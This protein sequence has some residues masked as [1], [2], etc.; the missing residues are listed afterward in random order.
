MDSLLS[1]EIDSLIH[2]QSDALQYIDAFKAFEDLV[3]DEDNAV[4]ETSNHGSTGGGVYDL[5]NKDDI[6]LMNMSF[7]TLDDKTKDG[8]EKFEGMKGKS[9][10]GSPREMGPPNEINKDNNHPQISCSN[11]SVMSMDD[12][13]S[14]RSS[15]DTDSNCNEETH[16]DSNC[17]EGTPPEV[18]AMHAGKRRNGHSRN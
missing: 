16:T 2:A 14:S 6:S 15:N 18:T 1:K 8:N 4:H 7:F 5:T 10:N 9:E 3:L 17:N 13:G 12:M 11:I